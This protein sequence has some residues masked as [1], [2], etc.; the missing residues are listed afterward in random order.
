MK[1][2]II[3][4]IKEIMINSHKNNYI[5]EGISQLEHAILTAIEAEEN[6]PNDYELIVASFLHDIGHQLLNNKEENIHTTADELC[7][8]ECARWN[9]WCILLPHKQ[10]HQRACVMDVKSASSATRIDKT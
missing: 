9:C 1:E 8:R 10:Q 3:S 6:Y 4:R 7:L 2:I 5:G